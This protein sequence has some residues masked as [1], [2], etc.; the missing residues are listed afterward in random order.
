MKSG[1]N[2]RLLKEQLSC[3]YCESV[4]CRE[5]KEVK[6]LKREL[7]NKNREMKFLENE[8]QIKDKALAEV[9][10]AFLLKKD[11]NELRG[12]ER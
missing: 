5:H 2:K 4:S 10:V 12:A 8:N 1:E 6:E 9:A 3:K 7:N 11:L